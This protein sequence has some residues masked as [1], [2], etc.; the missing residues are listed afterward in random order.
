M[1][2]YL[3]AC[4]VSFLTN[5]PATL[6]VYSEFHARVKQLLRRFQEAEEVPKA[7]RAA[8]DFWSDSMKWLTDVLWI[9]EIL[10]AG[11]S[12]GY[13][14]SSAGFKIKGTI[15]GE[16]FELQVKIG[17]LNFNSIIEA[18]GAVFKEL[19]STT[20][21]DLMGISS[22]QS[23]TGKLQVKYKIGGRH[24]KLL[25]QNYS[26]YGRPCRSLQ[27]VSSVTVRCITVPMCDFLPIEL[28]KLSDGTAIAQVPASTTFTNEAPT[29]SSCLTQC[30]RE[31]SPPGETF[32]EQLL[33]LT[34]GWCMVDE[35]HWGACS[36]PPPRV[37]LGVLPTTPVGMTFVNTPFI[38]STPFLLLLSSCGATKSR[39]FIS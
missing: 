1:S 39:L 5:F 3:I 4:L 2:E 35:S 26:C 21:G 37:A 25:S 38:V 10:I 8:P 6:D 18:L 17:P 36:C 27:S 29:G 12:Q 13:T 28:I 16:K 23:D 14:D 31:K 32:E 33:A 24:R 11:S 20:F 15:L 30:D 7:F 22:L 34:D 19:A 9:D